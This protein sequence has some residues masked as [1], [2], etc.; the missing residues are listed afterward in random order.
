MSH[1]KNVLYMGSIAKSQG[2]EKNFSDKSLEI[3]LI[4]NEMEVRLLIEAAIKYMKKSRR[5]R[6]EV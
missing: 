5:V 2:L 6:L 3:L 1:F 4:Y